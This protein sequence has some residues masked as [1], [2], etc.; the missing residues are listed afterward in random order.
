MSSKKSVKKHGSL[1]DARAKMKDRNLV[2]AAE[3]I[4]A[5]FEEISFLGARLEEDGYLPRKRRLNRAFADV[6]AKLENFSCCCDMAQP[7]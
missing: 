5:I 2:D 7:K 1:A 6:M 3:T 4:D